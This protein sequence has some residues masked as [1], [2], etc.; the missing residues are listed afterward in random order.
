MD[1]RPSGRDSMGMAVLLYVTGDNSPS[2][3]LRSLWFAHGRWCAI[4]LSATVYRGAV[5][6]LVLQLVRV[7]DDGHDGP[8]RVRVD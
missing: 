7:L 5:Q 1:T 8:P 2:G 4:T 6:K 3:R